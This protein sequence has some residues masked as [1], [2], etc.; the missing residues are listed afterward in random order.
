MQAGRQ[1]GGATNGK[2][3]PVEFVL[4]QEHDPISPTHHAHLVK[5]HLKIT[6]TVPLVLPKGPQNLLRLAE[7]SLTQGFFENSYV[8]PEFSDL[9]SFGRNKFYQQS[10]IVLSNRLRV[11]VANQFTVQGPKQIQQNV[12]DE[13]QFYSIQWFY[14]TSTIFFH[15]KIGIIIINVCCDHQKFFFTHTTNDSTNTSD[16]V[17]RITDQKISA[18]TSFYTGRP[19]CVGS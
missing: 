4:L 9:M 19:T 13:H 3:F 12:Q 16:G 18:S 1:K 17:R 15:Q 2:L 7:L 8:F 10:W 6:V 5:G 14:T 11:T